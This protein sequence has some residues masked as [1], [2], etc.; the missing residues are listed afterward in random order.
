MQHRKVAW[1]A[2]LAG[3]LAGCQS[4]ALSPAVGP[5]V[6]GVVNPLNGAAISG[7][8]VFQPRAGSVTMV[9]HVTGAAPGSYRVVIH[10]TGNCSSPNGFSAGAPWAPPGRSPAV[11]T[12]ASNTEGTLALSTE[13]AGLVV[14]GPDGIRGKSA[15]VHQGAVGPLDAKPGVS[16]DRIGC[17]VIG[18]ASTFSLIQ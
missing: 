17:A 10:A 11:L 1:F 15:V 9:V 4:G 7:S 6:G 13:L 5:E 3:A 12:M 18:D 2:L 16:N 14:D 8:V